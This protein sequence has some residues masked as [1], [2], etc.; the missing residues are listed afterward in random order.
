MLTPARA[1]ILFGTGDPTVNTTAPTGALAGSGWQYEGQFGSFLGTV[2]AANYFTTAKHIGGSV[3]DTVLVKSKSGTALGTQ[4]QV[5]KAAVGEQPLITPLAP[6]FDGPEAKRRP[7][8]KNSPAIVP[9]D[10]TDRPHSTF[11]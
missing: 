2:I 9:L 4:P 6:A 1:V 10:T 7:R 11:Q 3:G 5:S 8:P